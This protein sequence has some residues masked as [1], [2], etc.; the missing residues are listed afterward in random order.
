MPVIIP[1]VFAMRVS[2]SVEKERLSRSRTHI[3]LSL[4]PWGV[5]VLAR[6]I[7]GWT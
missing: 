6:S 5:A 1:V 4:V 7:C 3:L 2:P